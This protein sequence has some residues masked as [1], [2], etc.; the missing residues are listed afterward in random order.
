MNFW[1]IGRV[2]TVVLVA[3]IMQFSGV[4][5][6]QGQEHFLDLVDATVPSDGDV[7]PPEQL[8][9]ER[10]GRVTPTHSPR[11]VTPATIS[12]STLDRGRYVV[13]EKVIFEVVIT[14]TSG[15][16][17]AFPTMVDPRFVRRGMPGAT[18]ATIHR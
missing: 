18:L 17:L 4:H 12:L 15:R 3:G 9:V 5:A 16:A 14:N 6:Q 11:P 13:G 1:A 2:A 10:T 7:A 8:R